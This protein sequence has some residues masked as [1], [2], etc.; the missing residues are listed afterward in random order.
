VISEDLGH[1]HYAQYLGWLD[2]LG[3]LNSEGHS[4]PYRPFSHHSTNT[5]IP[6]SMTVADSVRAINPE[7][8]VPH[9]RGPTLPS[10]KPSVQPVNGE[11]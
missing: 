4:P 5:Y 9:S 8:V 10:A 2:G 7:A 1:R 3:L 6:F 11:H